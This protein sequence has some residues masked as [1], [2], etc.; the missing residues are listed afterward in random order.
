[1]VQ[2]PIEEDNIRKKTIDR[3]YT[4]ITSLKKRDNIVQFLNA[5]LTPTEKERLAK[6]LE[7]LK[8][9]RRGSSYK[10]IRNSLSVTDNTIA[11][12]SNILKEMTKKETK[13]LDKLIRED[14]LS[15]DKP[16]KFRQ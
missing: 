8:K 13:V 1:M 4:A 10:E 5:L 16:L 3:F 6:R 15:E 7:I 12:M 2:T 14:L 9:L 11:E